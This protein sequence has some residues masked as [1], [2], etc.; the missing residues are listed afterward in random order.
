MDSQ[1]VGGGQPLC[2]HESVGGARQIPLAYFSV[3]AGGTGLDNWRS[4][5]DN[6]PLSSR[7][8]PPGQRGLANF[9]NLF[10][11]VKSL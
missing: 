5:P 1:S 9:Q 6:N 4:S 7:L 3:A 11:I 10:G 8:M 2:P